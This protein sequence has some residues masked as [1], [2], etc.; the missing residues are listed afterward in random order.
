[1]QKRLAPEA[2]LSSV[3]HAEIY[4]LCNEKLEYFCLDIVS[5]QVEAASG[6]EIT[7]II[8]MCL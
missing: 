3:S 7:E 5:K 6:T 1:M 2:P 4:L 8:S